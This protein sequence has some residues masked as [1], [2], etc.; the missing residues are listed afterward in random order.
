ME[1]VIHLVIEDPPPK[2]AFMRIELIVKESLRSSAT[3]GWRLVGD[4]SDKGDQ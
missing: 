4:S 3:K 2:V 1:P